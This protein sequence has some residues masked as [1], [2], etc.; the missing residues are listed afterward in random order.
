MAKKGAGEVISTKA[1]T[2]AS[3]VLGDPKSSPAAKTAVAS[4]LMQRPNKK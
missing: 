3:K 1:A 2:A 4:A